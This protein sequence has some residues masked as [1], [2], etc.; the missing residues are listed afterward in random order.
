MNQAMK[1]KR[2]KGERLSLLFS[3]FLVLC[4]YY[5]I[6]GI[7]SLLFFL[8]L[9]FQLFYILVSQRQLI[10]NTLQVSERQ[11]EDIYKVAQDN[12]KDLNIKMPRIFIVQDPYLNAFTIGF[13]S[14]YAIVLTSSLVESLTKDEIDFV[15]GHEMGHIKFGHSK[16]LSFISPL[17]K[18]I[19]F[20]SWL[21]AF[22]QRKAEYTADRVGFFVVKEIRP[23]ISAMLKMTV[24]KKLSTLIDIEGIIE[25]IEE[26]RDGILSRTGELLLTH[27]YVT[28]RIRA[29]SEYD[30][31]ER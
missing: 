12:A 30:Y 9:I 22:W 15:I 21:Y 27:P 26:S 10:G 18:D 1:L 6:F 29:L 3:L 8:A 7:S 24:G 4:F 14:P 11:F 2:Y 23:T 13:K 25:Q 28:N 17:G 31:F 5:L 20:V 16:I 19:P